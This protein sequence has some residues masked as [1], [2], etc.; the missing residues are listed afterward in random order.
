MKEDLP[1]KLNSRVRGVLSRYQNKQYQMQRGNSG[2]KVEHPKQL[3]LNLWNAQNKK[4]H[5]LRKGLIAILIGA[6]IIAI[7]TCNYFI[8]SRFSYN[9]EI[10]KIEDSMANPEKYGSEIKQLP[11]ESDYR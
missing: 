4:R 10:D 7:P 5:R 11:G 9:I 3:K 2:L 6:G 8:H 1:P